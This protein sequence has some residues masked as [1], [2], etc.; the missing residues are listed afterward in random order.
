MAPAGAGSTS[1]MTPMSGPGD[2]IRLGV[3]GAGNIAELNVAG[4]LEDDRC[5]V[6]AVCDTNKD[7]AQA[8]AT[9]WGAAK[10]FTAVDDLL[11]DPA[12]D[13]VEILTPTHLHYEHVMAAVAA[14]K[15]V[16]CQKP[17]SNTVEQSWKMGAAAEAAGVT[18]RVSEC[19]YHYPPLERAK[20]LIADGAIGHP[21][22]VRIRT[23]VG[24]TKAAFQAG[25]RADGYVW[26][27]NN[28]SPGGHL[29]DDMVHKYA[30]ALWLF[31]QD[32]VSVQ[33]VV[34]RR[35]LFFEPCA[36]IFE[37][38][39]E[40]LLGSM[41]VSYAPKMWMRSAYY[42]ADEFVEV[43]GDEGFLWVTR[44]TGRDARPGPGHG[45]PGRRGRVL[46]DGLLRHG[47][48][49]GHRLQALLG[50]LHRLS[51]GR[52]AG[53]HERR[54]GGQ[55]PPALLRRLPGG[56]HP[57]SGRSPHHHRVGHP[58]RLGRL[59]GAGCR[60]RQGHDRQPL[61]SIADDGTRRGR[62]P[63][64]PVLA[65]QGVQGDGAP[66]PGLPHLG[67]SVD[68]HPPQVGPLLVVGVDQQSRPAGW[69]RTF[70]SRRRARVDLGLA[71]TAV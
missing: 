54:P 49:L 52:H 14:G 27:L 51:P 7:V 42:G 15:H 57:G 63:V 68:P 8:A 34:R 59:V 39:D 13:A 31:D 71:S 58:H 17:L 40:T 26:R 45:L 69:E 44:C 60:S 66:G 56:Q 11:D 23:V 32:I 1:N 46:D 5:E 64:L 18:L 55:G 10:V 41:E 61:I 28:M 65:G 22:N 2:R 43:Q 48:R 35:D 19:F 24:Q 29:F 12:I 9:A 47:R 20:K 3:I 21:T 36:A 62:L 50:P 25:L 6:V 16:S 53:R 70:S 33:A 37:Y 38:E 4:Y 67:P 30:M